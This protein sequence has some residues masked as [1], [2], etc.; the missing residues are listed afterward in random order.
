MHTGDD[1][2]HFKSRQ[3]KIDDEYAKRKIKKYSI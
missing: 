3:F 2:I 1:E